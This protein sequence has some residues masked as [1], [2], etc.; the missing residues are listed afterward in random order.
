M[1]QEGHWKGT[2]LR[3]LR[4]FE[5]QVWKFIV[6]NY[7]PAS[8]QST[9]LLPDTSW[10]ANA[11]THPF[12]KTLGHRYSDYF[13][14]CSKKSQRASLDKFN[15]LGPFILNSNKFINFL[16]CNGLLDVKSVDRFLLRCHIVDRFA[17]HTPLREPSGASLHTK[18]ELL[19]DVCYLLCRLLGV[20][21]L[22]DN[23][24]PSPRQTKS[25]TRTEWGKKPNLPH[26]TVKQ[27][28]SMCSVECV[29]PQGPPGVHARTSPLHETGFTHNGKN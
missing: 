29:Y 18:V 24:T 2:L 16:S 23:V 27:Q 6:F 19:Y 26:T 8:R 3:L 25:G 5:P 4:A 1:A 28:A 17:H 22:L 14:Q 13:L 15:L 20:L 9:R 21:V 11:P 7:L 10:K 12:L